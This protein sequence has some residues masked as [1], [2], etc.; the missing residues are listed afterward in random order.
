MDAM[1]LVQL[2]GK[3]DIFLTVTCSRTWL[4][5]KKHLSDHEEAHNRPNLTTRVL[6]TKLEMLRN[7]I[8]KKKSLWQSRGIHICNRISKKR[9][10]TCT[11][12]YNPC[13]WMEIG[14]T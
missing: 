7:D 1:I 2:Y 8:I 11:F 4:E 9:S 10:P 5:I 12:F 6:R 14:L 13:K 3:L